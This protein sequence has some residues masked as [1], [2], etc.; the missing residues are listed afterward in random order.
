MIVL[1]T[2]KQQA[3]ERERARQFQEYSHWQIKKFEETGQMP[4]I[5]FGDWLRIHREIQR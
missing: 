3:V 4:M 5:T 1:L 2:P